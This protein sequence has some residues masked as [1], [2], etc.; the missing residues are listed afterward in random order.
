MFPYVVGGLIISFAAWNVFHHRTPRGAIEFSGTI[1]EEL[2]KIS[3][4]S[5]SKSRVYAPRV[6]YQHPRTG[7]AEVYEPTRFEL[8][9]HTVGA[10]TPLVYDPVTDRL[11]RPLDRPVK[12]TLVLVGAGLFFIFFPQISRA[13]PW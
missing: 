4:S 7:T 9:R 5:G 6:A 10:Q 1:V 11:S 8:H 13:L 3:G 2:T 12:D